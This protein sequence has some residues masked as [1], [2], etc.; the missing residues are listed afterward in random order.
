ML[1]IKDSGPLSSG[2]LFCNATHCV[3]LCH[4]ALFELYPIVEAVEWHKRMLI[5]GLLLLLCVTKFFVFDPGVSCLLPA[6]M[7]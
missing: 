1:I 3:Y 7:K 6:P 4:M 2:F 5:L